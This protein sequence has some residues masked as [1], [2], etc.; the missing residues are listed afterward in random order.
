MF[1]LETFTTVNLDIYYNVLVFLAS[2]DIARGK[3]LLGAL[4]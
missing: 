3:S 1:D 4:I 2:T